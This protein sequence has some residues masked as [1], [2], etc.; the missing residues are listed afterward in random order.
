LK[1]R[2]SWS[3]LPSFF[4]FNSKETSASTSNIDTT[5]KDE[6]T[7]EAHI[8]SLLYTQSIMEST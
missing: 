3:D 5:G 8:V 2:S 1:R 7:N 6:E 4:K